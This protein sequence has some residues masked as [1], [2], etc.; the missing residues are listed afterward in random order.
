MT[1]IRFIAFGATYALLS[2]CIRLPEYPGSWAARL[3]LPENDCPDLNGAFSEFG[4]ARQTTRQPADTDYVQLT[5]VVGVS[6]L[7][8]P[9]E[10]VVLRVDA[11][12][13]TITAYNGKQPVG[14]AEFKKLGNCKGGE[15]T[16]GPSDSRMI[17]D[18]GMARG[19][20]VR[21][22]L[23]RSNDG[24]L[25]LRRFEWSGGRALLLAPVPSVERS[26]LRFP[27][28]EISE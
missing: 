4:S 14:M 2:G 19:T 7:T 22:G 13:L 21:I 20:S 27:K 9:A 6:R 24:A 5:R 10:R 25:V 11:E 18:G 3:D 28:I 8:M 16:I 26:W 15:F 1:W 23:S 12:K 17:N